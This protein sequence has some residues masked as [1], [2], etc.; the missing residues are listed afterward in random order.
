VID[1]NSA[2]TDGGGLNVQKSGTAEAEQTTITHNTAGRGG[3][4]FNSGGLSLNGSQVRL[5]TA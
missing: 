2:W 1:S 4:I 5:N 3:G